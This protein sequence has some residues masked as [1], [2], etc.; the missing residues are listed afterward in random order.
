MKLKA[1]NSLAKCFVLISLFCS[2]VYAKPE[3]FPRQ[4]GPASVLPKKFKEEVTMTPVD[5][6]FETPDHYTIFDR[7]FNGLPDSAEQRALYLR[8]NSAGNPNRGK[9]STAHPLLDKKNGQFAFIDGF[10]EAFLRR[11]TYWQNLWSQG[12]S[13]NQTLKKN[14]KVTIGASKETVNSF[15]SVVANVKLNFQDSSGSAQTDVSHQSLTMTVEEQ[16]TEEEA[17]DLTTAVGEP[18]TFTMWQYVEELAIVDKNQNPINV[19]NILW[20]LYP[21]PA[22]RD[23]R[24]GEQYQSYAGYS[25]PSPVEIRGQRFLDKAVV[26]ASN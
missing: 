7:Y 2:T 12:M 11:T 1:I 18:A 17:L 5:I 24:T 9:V 23:S 14:I 16:R 19:D 13:A 4:E 3:N 15:T 22:S 25:S 8:P 20:R 26:S 6:F 21:D 10:P